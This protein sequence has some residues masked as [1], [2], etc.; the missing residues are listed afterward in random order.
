M[1]HRTPEEF[2]EQ[3]RLLNITFWENHKCS[4]C[5]TPVGYEFKNGESS[6]NSNC[7][8]V[9]YTSPNH[10]HGWQEVANSYNLQSHP[11]VIKKMDKF[12]GFKTAKA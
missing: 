6:Y 12:W 11:D 8:C 10:S 4:I 5:N 1:I 9:N 2:K 3:A 7:S